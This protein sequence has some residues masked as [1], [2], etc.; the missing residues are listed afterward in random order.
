MRLAALVGRLAPNT[1][2]RPIASGQGPQMSEVLREDPPL[3][4]PVQIR[5]GPV[6]VDLFTTITTLGTAQDITLQE[7]RVEV[8]YPADARSEQVL[9]ALAAGAPA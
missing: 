9:R 2:V 3:L 1:A 5:R 6:E 7:L 8:F 4:I